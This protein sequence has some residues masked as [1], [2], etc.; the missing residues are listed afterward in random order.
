MRPRRPAHELLRFQ[1]AISL[2]RLEAYRSS[3]L[4]TQLDLLSTYLWNIGLCE[5]F[6]PALHN[7]EIALRNSLYQ[8]IS[9]L[10]HENW[11][12]DND[13][14]IL[15]PQEMRLVES[16]IIS[17]GR[18]K[19]RV[20]TGDLISELNLGFWVSLSYARYEGKDNLYPRIFRDNDFFPHLPRSQRT[21]GT[22]SRQLTSI[23]KL[24]NE[25]FHHD[26]IWNK[27][28]LRREYDDILEAIQW[29]SPMLCEATKQLS[30]FPEVH[31]QGRNV[32]I[33]SLESIT[34]VSE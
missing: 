24:R 7:F 17:L 10:F 32:Y 11:L 28:E 4:D 6:Y 8:A 14:R 2:Q 18:K 29:I 19:K 27:K 12:S 20:S 31:I 15:Q 23:R 21:R 22:L 5:A 9:K 13:P 16:A 33:N 1:Q 26:P 3:S 30:R 34:T 25:I